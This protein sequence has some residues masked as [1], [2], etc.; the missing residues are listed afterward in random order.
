MRKMK[1]TGTIFFQVL[2]KKEDDEK[3]ED[4]D[5]GYASMSS[6]EKDEDDI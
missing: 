1:N 5:S 4:A 6:G 2:F 3:D